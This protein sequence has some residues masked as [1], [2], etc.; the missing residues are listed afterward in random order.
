VSPEQFVQLEPVPA[1]M[2]VPVQFVKLQS[3]PTVIEVTAVQSVK[4]QFALE[5]LVVKEAVAEQAFN[6][7][8]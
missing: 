4:E 5:L 7:E 2:V 1:V 8:A 3:V 6:L